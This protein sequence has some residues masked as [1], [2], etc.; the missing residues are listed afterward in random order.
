MHL[1]AFFSGCF[2][3]EIQIIGEAV[4]L[5]LLILRPHGNGI[6]PPVVRGVEIP[7]VC[8][9]VACDSRQ[10]N[11]VLF[12]PALVPSMDSTAFPQIGSWIVGADT[13]GILCCSASSRAFIVS[14]SS[15]ASP[16]V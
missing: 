14:S 15:L 1:S 12:F 10:K 11:A 9:G 8:V 16:F 4:L 2:E 7:E 13:K 6:F 3:Q 5:L